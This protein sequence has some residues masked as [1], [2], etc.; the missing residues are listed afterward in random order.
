[1]L[2]GYGQFLLKMSKDI[3]GF[4]GSKSKNLIFMLMGIK[5]WRRLLRWIASGE[6]GQEI[7]HGLKEVKNKS[8]DRSLISNTAHRLLTVFRFLAVICIAGAIY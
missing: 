8:L 4:L 2:A 5:Y 6:A 7:A 1:M 3:I